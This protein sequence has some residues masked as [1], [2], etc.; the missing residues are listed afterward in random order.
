M[1]DVK[2]HIKDLYYLDLELILQRVCAQ[3]IRHPSA[4]K[5]L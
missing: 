5:N 3:Q 1:D 2:L 4:Y